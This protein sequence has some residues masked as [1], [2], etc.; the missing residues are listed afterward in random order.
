MTRK[1]TFIVI[2]ALIDI[3]ICGSLHAQGD[4]QTIRARFWEEFERTQQVIDRAGA[5]IAESRTEKGKIL[6]D[7]ALALQDQAGKMG[8]N[9]MYANGMDL[10]FEAREKAHSAIMASQ[11]ADENENLVLRQLEKT[12]NLIARVR[13]KMPSDVPQMFRAMFDSARK[14]QRQAWEFF[15]NRSLRAALKMSRQAEK[16]IRKLIE[17]FRSEDNEAQRILNHLRQAEQKYEQAQ[18]DISQCGHK[19][20]QRLLDEARD[21]LEA[22]RRFV[23]DGILKRAENSFKT[24]HRLMNRAKNLCSDQDIMNEILPQLRNEVE[25]L[26]EMLVGTD[27]D[28][29][30]RLVESAR[31]HLEDAE[32]LCAAGHVKRCAANIKAAQMSIQKAKKL[33]E[34]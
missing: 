4:Q 11:Q 6:L 30:M 20:A 25:R 5:I 14:N 31:D 34:L 2:L 23:A 8:R 7:L 9:G 3:L 12:D 22:S 32:R 15:R 26:S 13:E 21:H 1:L 27:N 24:A 19:E 28:K 33:M 18:L 17:R 10:T 16:A 29:A